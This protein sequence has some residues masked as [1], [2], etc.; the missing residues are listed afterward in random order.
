[1]QPITINPFIKFGFLISQV[2]LLLV[3]GNNLLI[4]LI[5]V[6]SVVYMI[7]KRVPRQ[8]VTNGLKF[9]LLLTVFIFA[10]SM[11]RYQDLQ[12]AVYNGLYLFKVYL[13]MIMVSVVYK[14][15]TSNKELAYVLSVI[16][17]PFKVVGFDQNKLYTLFLMI[18]NQIFTM[19]ESALRMHKYAKF[20][21]ADKLSIADTAKLVIPFINSNLKHN[22]LLAIGLINSGYN[23]QN[24]TIKPYFI[25][26]YKWSYVIIL[27]V[28]ISLELII[29]I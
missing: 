6:Y 3:T 28:I 13:A 1:M 17:S 29:L 2:I 8:L 19:R 18:L 14:M 15:E 9:G 20:K 12:L 21:T 11:I 5:L 24:K 4:G 25:T 22:E 10:F 27:V 16:F 26:N 7:V 23:S